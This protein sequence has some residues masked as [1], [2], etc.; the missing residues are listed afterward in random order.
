M[1]YWTDRASKSAGDLL[2]EEAAGLS[3][4]A[5]SGE[6]GPA[7]LGGMPWQ[8]PDTSAVEAELEAW[9]TEASQTG[10]REAAA[11]ASYLEA[12][13]GFVGAIPS[14]EL[15]A[16]DEAEGLWPLELDSDPEAESM[17]WVDE[18][19]C[20]GCKFCATVARSTF[21]MARGTVVPWR[22]GALTRPVPRL[23]GGPE[24]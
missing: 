8:A 22:Y 10:A 3:V 11:S 6:R 19:S 9:R 5:E 12:R 24:S 17:I 23:H 18:I 15:L 16:R 7:E 4:A 13:D 2:R 20:I 21:S 1:D 14:S